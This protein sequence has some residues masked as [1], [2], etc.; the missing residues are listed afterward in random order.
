LIFLAGVFIAF[1]ARCDGLGMGYDSGSLEQWGRGSDLPPPLL[2]IEIFM[3]R[4]FIALLFLASL[5]VSAQAQLSQS[6]ISGTI[7]ALDGSVKSGVKV[8]VVRVTQSGSNINANTNLETTSAADG[9]WSLTLPRSSTAWFCSPNSS[10]ISGMSSDCNRATA[11]TIPNSASATFQSLTTV[12]SFPTGGFVVKDEGTSLS[13]V[14]TTL[15]F[16]GSGVAATQAS[17][18]VATI[19][20]SGGSGS[21]T[22]TDF[23]AGNLSPLFTSSVATSTSTPALT[24]SLSTQ[25]ANRIFAGPTTGSAAAP[26]FRALVAADIPDISGTYQ[27]L[28]SDLTTIA[29]LT[30]TNDDVLQRKA[31]AWVNRSIAQLKTDLGYA[32]IATSGSASDLGSGTVPLA[33]LSGITTAELSATAGITNGQLAGSI[34]FSKIA[35]SGTPDG[36]KFVRDDGSFQNIPGGGDALTSNPLSQFASTTSAQLAGVLSNE[37]GTGVAV[38]NDTPTLIAPILGTPTSGTLTNATGL[39]IST[40]VSGLGTG[41]ATA[42]GVNVGSAGAPVLFNGAGGTPSSLTLTNGTGLPIGGITGLGTGVGTWL[43]TPSSAN[44]ASA[45]TDETGSGALV[46]GTSPDF[47]TGAT[48]GGVAIPTISSTSTLT[49]KTISGASNTLTNIA[50]ASL[51]NSG[52]TIAGTPTSLGAAITLDTITGLSST[53]I[54]KRTAAN[55]LAIATSGTDYAPATSGN[56]ILYGNGSGGFSAVTVGSG[57]DFTGGTLTATG[58]GT[59]DVVG[60]SSATDNAVARFDLTTGKLIQDSVVTIADTSGNMAGVGTLNGHTIPGGT[61]TFAMLGTA[62]TFTANQTFGSGIL[63]ATSPRVATSILDANGNTLVGA[64]A[65]SSAVN[66]ATITN[67]AAS[68]NVVIGTDGS[69]TAVPL[70]LYPKG[71]AYPDGPQVYLRHGARYDRPELSWPGSLKNYGIHQNSGG[72]WFSINANNIALGAGGA[73]SGAEAKVAMLRNTLLAWGDSL[74]TPIDEVDQDLFLGRRA[75]ATFRFGKPDVAG[76]PVAQT[77]TVQGASGVSNTAGA[78]TTWK[79]SAGTGTGAGGSLIWQVAPAGSSGST[80]NSYQTALTIASDKSAT[81]TGD[82]QGTTATFSGAISVASCTGCG[83]GLS[84]GDKG[85]I[86]VSSSGTVWTIDNSAVSNAK[87]TN[88]AITIAGTSTSLGGSI[89]QDTITGLSSTGLIKRTG[90]NTLAT[91]TAGTDYASA[92]DVTSSGLTMA[93]A[94]LL[95]RSTAS[96]G[97]VEEISIGSGLSLSAGTL[98]ASGG[99]GGLTIGTT[100]ITSGT[101]GRFLYETSGNVVGQISTLTSDGTIV[102]FAP[103]VTTGSGST[104][105]LA[106]TANS[107]TTGNAFDFSSSSVTTGNVVSIAATGTAAASNTKTALRVATSGANGTST[108]TTYG[109][110][111]TNTSTGTSSTNVGLY[112]AASGGTV[113][114]GIVIGAGNLN[115][116]GTAS[117]N[118][119]FQ[120][121]GTGG[122]FRR[123][124]DSNLSG[125]IFGGSFTTGTSG[126]RKAMIDAGNVAPG[127]FMSSDSTFYFANSTNA[128]SSIN[129]LGVKFKSSGLLEINAG[130]TG[131]IGTTPGNARDLMLRRTYFAETTSD[132][133]ASELSVAGGNALDVAAVYVKSNK[134]VIAYNN[135]GT[136]TYITIPL[137]GSTTTWTHSTSA[138]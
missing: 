82:I 94:R 56:S 44:L 53:G 42:L 125:E 126:A 90:A 36:T 122:A 35:I 25:S 85:D 3:K 95:G 1:S 26:T 80:Q 48:I 118:V 76:A 127:I 23:S 75:S 130:S 99:G 123:G 89:T 64:T 113:N 111:F 43:A 91:A 98:S 21:G 7:Y 108:Q 62:Q 46:F 88:S 105:G 16:V 27:P 65:T 17:P 84:D 106:A 24:F 134:L 60:P 128:T 9:T 129:T 5:A 116:G 92:G 12:V 47:T 74:E 119:M 121:N 49:N 22:V 101:G 67:A 86:T 61:D 96:T 6:T 69:D 15:N 50:N 4:I 54:V 28:D 32:T 19:T 66:Y 51:S 120:P 115:F 137:D 124:D 107:L 102:T 72:G 138:P 55:T 37:T 93:T 132:P 33:R 97:A 30:A 70:Y 73:Q 79:A 114:A 78:N 59:G 29:G 8:R 77:F 39:P 58:G 20:I 57:L 2:L 117:S 110:Y 63:R 14:A 31:G 104:A 83:G 10:V 131:A 136:V 87:L 103:T 18:G 52:I 11:K 38:F 45:I 34:A 109:G 71:G 112:A 68:G 81:F 135:S 40:G 133:S 13:D 41:I 100:T